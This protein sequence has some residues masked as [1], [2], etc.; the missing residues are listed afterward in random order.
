MKSLYNLP[1]VAFVA[2]DPETIVAEVVRSYETQSGRSIAK[3]DPVRQL[4]LAFANIIIIQ[5][6][7]INE[8]GKQNLLMYA[9]GDNLDHIGVQVG[10]KRLEATASKTTIKIS[11]S[12]TR[13]KATLI[14]QGTRFTA[15]DNVFF[16]LDEM[17]IIDAGVD[18][19]SGV[20]SCTEA[21]VIG[22]DYLPE[23]IKILVDPVPFVAAVS[24]ITRSEGGSDVESDN[25]FRERIRIAPESFSVAGPAGAYEYHTKRAS[26]SII[27]VAVS[28]PAPGEVEVRPLLVDGEIPGEE[29]LNIVLE[30]L[31]DRSVRPLTDHVSVLPPSS[32][33][34]DIDLTYYIDSN[35][36]AHLSTIRDNVV[37][38][39]NEYALW[40]KG[41]LGRNIIPS[42]LIRK[43]MDAGAWRVD[44]SNPVFTELRDTEVAIARDINIVFGGVEDE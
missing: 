31:N 36:Q 30:A 42:E 24:N 35:S 21:G 11:L 2:T 3:G 37:K 6:V 5:R 39:V 44:V 12:E 38:A 27:D 26:A 4:L 9:S 29:M 20:A 16:A 18:E 40:Q 10:V 43:V 22:N 15:G 33:D 1:E 19:G 32:V 13:D 7:L 25:E 23:Q 17:L 34:Y 28:S 14:P 8:T 41:K